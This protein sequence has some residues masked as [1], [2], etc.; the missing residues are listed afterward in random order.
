MSNEINGNEAAQASVNDSEQSSTESGVNIPESSEDALQAAMDASDA[1]R[2]IVYVTYTNLFTGVLLLV[3]GI[4]N[5]DQAALAQKIG[6]SMAH[7]TDLIAG[8][9][10]HLTLENI[11]MI[12]AVLEIN[13]YDLLGLVYEISTSLGDETVCSMNC[14]REAVFQHLAANNCNI[15]EYGSD[16]IANYLSIEPSHH[17]RII[18]LCESA[19]LDEN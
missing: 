15:C 8:R 13:V 5:V 12:T 14:E 10:S 9:G 16:A 7:W 18:A 11:Y 6:L 17:E 19:T 1:N 3:L 4:R 2:E